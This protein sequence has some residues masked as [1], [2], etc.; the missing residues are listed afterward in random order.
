MQT[1][2]FRLAPTPSGFIHAGNAF[3]FRLTAERCRQAGGVLRLRIDDLDRQRVR[4]EYLQSIF[5]SLQ[6]LHIDWQE[7]PQTVAEHEATFSQTLRLPRYNELLAGLVRCNKVFA[8]RCSRAQIA[9]HSRDGHYSGA[10]EKEAIPL[11]TPDVTWRVQT[12]PESKGRF[13]DS[14]GAWVE[15]D[16]AV[17]NPFFVVRRRDGLPAY[18]IAS[19][20]DDVDYGITDIVRG[21]DL[22][23][24]TFSQAYLA[25]MLQLEAFLHIRF[26]HHPLLLG[27]D[28]E[29]L[30]KSAGAKALVQKRNEGLY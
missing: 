30:S 6:A 25:E 11:D 23:R 27:A 29:K 4:P 15:A 13:R 8:C 5:D 26:E 10:C 3:N 14:D 9:A 12:P 18:H 1:R 19:L 7:G 2:F 22:R 21:E 24:S 16:L 20:A 17:E 28:G